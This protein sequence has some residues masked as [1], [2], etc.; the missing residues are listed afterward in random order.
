MITFYRIPS[1]AGYFSWYSI[2]LTDGSI[3][4]FIYVPQ[5]EQLPVHKIN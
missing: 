3:D 4:S 1:N 5:V 2:N